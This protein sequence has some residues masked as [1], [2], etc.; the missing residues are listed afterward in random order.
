MRGWG[1]TWGALRA[2]SPPSPSEE[3]ARRGAHVLS[4]AWGK[5]S[6]VG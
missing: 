3:G 5:L 2:A 4:G 1:S 6:G